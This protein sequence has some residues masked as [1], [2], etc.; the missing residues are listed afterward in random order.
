MFRKSASFSR[1]VTSSFTVSLLF[2]GCGGSNENLS[3]LYSNQHQEDP[4][5]IFYFEEVETPRSFFEMRDRGD[6]DVATAVSGGEMEDPFVFI[7]KM[8]NLGKQA[9]TFIDNN[10]PVVNIK[11]DYASAVPQGISYFNQME[12]FSDLQHTSF[13]FYAKNLMGV[14]VFDVNY[15]LVHQYNGSYNG[16][17]KYLTNVGVIPSQVDV[18]WGYSLD[19]TVSN[20]VITNVGSKEAPIASIM[21]EL[22]SKVSTMIKATTKTRVF[23]F[24]GDRAEPVVMTM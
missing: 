17:G 14:T 3:N 23:Q 2:A 12:D 19:F 15:T 10:K 4:E 18:L 9:W 24:R 20:L 7:D 21:M 6:F 16:F 11:Y 22:R 1:M 5:L 13:R 8:I